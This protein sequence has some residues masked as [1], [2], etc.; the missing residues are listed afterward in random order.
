MTQM[1]SDMTT[2]KVICVHLRHL[3]TI[4]KTVRQALKPALASSQPSAPRQCF[5]E[6]KSC[7]RPRLRGTLTPHKRRGIISLEIER[8]GSLFRLLGEIAQ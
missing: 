3:R 5:F 4:P 2:I 7:H 1:T 8:H 6:P